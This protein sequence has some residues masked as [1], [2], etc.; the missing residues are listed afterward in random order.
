T[1]ALIA[2]LED[3]ATE[4]GEIGLN[5]LLSE[6]PPV[7]QRWWAR[8]S[9]GFA[10]AFFSFL[11]GCTSLALSIAARAA[12]V[13]VLWAAPGV[14]RVHEM[15]YGYAI[16]PNAGLW[17]LA[18]TSVCFLIGFGFLDAAHRGLA[19]TKTLSVAD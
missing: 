7:V 2:D 15:M 4:S 5:P 19:R 6:L 17:Y 3:R 1:E 18:G 10:V 9:S 8:R 14:A 13:R 16:E 12:C 11:W